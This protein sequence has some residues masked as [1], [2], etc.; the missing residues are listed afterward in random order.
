MAIARV[1][2]WG[3]T[4]VTATASVTPAFGQSTSAGS[5]LVAKVAAN[6]LTASIATASSGWTIVAIPTTSA[7]GGA[8]SA[9]AYKANCGAGETAPTFTCTGASY[10]S[11]ALEEYSGAALSSPVRAFAQ[12]LAMSSSTAISGDLLVSVRTDINSKSATCTYTNQGWEDFGPVVSLVGTDLGDQDTGATKGLQWIYSAGFIT[13]AGNS[14]PFAGYNRVTVAVST[15]SVVGG[16]SGIV[17][18]MPLASMPPPRLSVVNH[19]AVM[20]SAVY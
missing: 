5:L 16:H 13:S 11:A 2:S 10:M 4:S 17:A 8:Q 12:T 14:D 9:I 20:R 6:V 3:S 15:G 18:F 1:G 7:T 19:N